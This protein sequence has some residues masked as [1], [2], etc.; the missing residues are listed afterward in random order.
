MGSGAAIIAADPGWEFF[1][2]SSQQWWV[3]SLALV[4]RYRRFV[5]P[6]APNPNTRSLSMY[7]CVG[8]VTHPFY[9]WDFR[10]PGDLSPSCALLIPFGTPIRFYPPR[11]MNGNGTFTF[12]AWD[13]TLGDPLSNICQDTTDPQAGLTPSLSSTTAL[14]YFPVTPVNNAPY[15]TGADLVAMF[16]GGSNYVDLGSSAFGGE[17]TFSLWAFIDN[18]FRPW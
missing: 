3:A 17:L 5:T 7:A 10:R 12:A 6:K 4:W 11:Y 8:I 1:E 2:A 16:D 14:A 18:P 9:R 15:V 13:G